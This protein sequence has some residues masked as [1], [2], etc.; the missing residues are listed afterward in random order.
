MLEAQ[1]KE[2]TVALPSDRLPW[3]RLLLYAVVLRQH[4]AELASPARLLQG[5]TRLQKK[6]M[7][8]DPRLARDNW[9]VG[10]PCNANIGDQEPGTRMIAA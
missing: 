2:V 8:S 3:R 5:V 10:V 1:P 4:P 7:E 9:A 6:L